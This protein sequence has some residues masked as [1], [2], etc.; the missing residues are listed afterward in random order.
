MP[1]IMPFLFTWFLTR[2][3]TNEIKSSWKPCVACLQN[4]INFSCATTKTT[5]VYKKLLH[6]LHVAVSEV[7]GVSL[8]PPPPHWHV[9]RRQSNQ[10]AKCNAFVKFISPAPSNR[11]SVSQCTTAVPKRRGKTRFSTLWLLLPESE[12]PRK[13]PSSFVS[14]AAAVD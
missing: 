14:T 9:R 10:L 8:H 3:F 2:N 5:S 7:S 11:H 12:N 13:A 6:H 1:A 4:K